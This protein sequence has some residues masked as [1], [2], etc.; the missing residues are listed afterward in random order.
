MSKFRLPR[1][2]KKKLKKTIWLYSA[3]EKGN[4]LMAFPTRNQEDYTAYKQGKLRDISKSKSKA[5]RKKRTKI[6]ENPIEVTE[7]ELKEYVTEIF[8]EDYREHALR[9]LNNAQ[10]HPNTIVAY[11]H[12]VNAYKLA[13]A[14][15]ESYANTCCLSIDYAQKLTKVNSK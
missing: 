6:L 5:E 3:D 14:G 10:K 7:S 1:K 11:Y 12:F 4:S 13:K 9:T 15:K 2:V 8:R